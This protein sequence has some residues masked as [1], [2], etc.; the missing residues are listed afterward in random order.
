MKNDTWIISKGGQQN[1]FKT[2][3]SGRVLQISADGK[4]VN[5][6]AYGMRNGFI[7]SIPEKDLL[8]ASDQQGNWVPSTPFHIVRKG[9]FLGYEPGGP[10]KK[11]EVQ[12]AAL[13]FPHRI[14][15]SGIDPLWGSDPRLG[16]LHKSILYIEY[17]KPSLIK[18][19]IPDEG[20][21]IQ[22]AG[23]PLDLEF[24]VPLLKG[25][26]NPIDGMAYMVGFQ[27]WDSF[28]KR[29]E[30][31]CR[32][33][34]LGKT[35]SYPTW[36]ELFKEGILLRFSQEL[37]PEIAMDPANYLVSSWEYLRQAEYGSAQYKADGTPGAD[38]RFVHSTLLSED[39]KSVFIAIDNMTTTMQL[40][41]QHHLF[42]SWNPVYF[43]ANELP[44]VSLQEHGFKKVQFDQLF[45][46][47]PTPREVSKLKTIVSEARGQE[48][49]TL[50]GCIGCHSLDGTTEGKSGPTWKGI[51]DKKRTLS[52]GST[53][54]VDDSYLKESILEPA[55]LMLTGFDGAEA[56]MPPY[57]GILSDAD[58]ESVILF[59]RS[60]K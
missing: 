10:V 28:A 37:E 39:G 47:T 60:L 1:D 50:Y 19:L 51:Y 27:I 25:G 9:S 3:H 43:T 18:V 49:S 22:T 56:G 17:K 32:L 33:R 8:V 16:A 44:S 45:S 58:I 57:K 5:Y 31:L 11:T 6:W 48:L 34:V 53:V 4:A 55:K 41:V 46:S 13:W 29:L 7:N 42:E 2:P 26:I 59:I 14:A 40:E 30:G 24:E 23:I 12:P 36:A 52:D 38:G 21:I 54:R 35:D 15:Q 20:E